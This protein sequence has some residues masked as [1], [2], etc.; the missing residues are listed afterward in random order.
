MTAR[1]RS[2]LADRVS[3]YTPHDER[4]WFG[5]G[6]VHGYEDQLIGVAVAVGRHA[7][8]LHRKLDTRGVGAVDKIPSADISDSYV[9]PE[10]QRELIA[11]ELEDLARRIR[12]GAFGSIPPGQVATHHQAEPVRGM[13]LKVTCTRPGP[14]P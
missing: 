8:A 14:L 7:V 9:W 2:W 1:V 11:V 10:D 13:H 6:A 12:S 4:T 3:F 5:V